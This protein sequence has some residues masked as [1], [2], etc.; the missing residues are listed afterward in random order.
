LTIVSA[1]GETRLELGKDAGKW[2]VRILHPPPH[3]GK[4][5][6]EAGVRVAMVGM[7]D[8][9]LFREELLADGAEIAHIDTGSPRAIIFFGAREKAQLS[10]LGA[11]RR[12][13]APGGA[14]WV[15]YPKGRKEITESGVMA[16][17]RVSGLVDIK[18]AAFS[19][20]PTA[21]KPVVRK[22]APAAR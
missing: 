6:V 20:T 14:V 12:R 22:A 17:C 7:E 15:V 5:G 11:L 19:T 3:A 2:A 1:A 21:R 4:L 13:L 10:N 8:D 16:A 18:V 9:E